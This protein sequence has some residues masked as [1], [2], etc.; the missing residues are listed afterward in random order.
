ML[1]IGRSGGLPQ[2]NSNQANSLANSDFP[3]AEKI[4][5]FWGSAN[6]SGQAKKENPDALAG[7]IGAAYEAGNFKAKQYRNLVT[8]SNRKSNGTLARFMKPQHM[9]M[10]RMLGYTLTLGTPEAWAGFR[11]VAGVRLSEGERAMM[12]Y[13]ALTALRPENADLTACTA[14]GSA[15][16]PL[17]AFLG[18]MEDARHWAKW[19]NASELKAYAL[20]CFEAMSAKDQ[21]AFFRH[22]S[23]MEVAR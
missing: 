8:S 23:T 5:E 7:A 20:A 1:R 3:A 14:I 19:A 6:R 2:H 10:S 21:A 16:D 18:G 12:A 17:P 4:E 15:G 13:F 11:Y 9:R 22:I